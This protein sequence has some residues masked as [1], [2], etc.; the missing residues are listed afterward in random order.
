MLGT[1]PAWLV[2]DAG[3]ACLSQVMVKNGTR[4]GS[5][6][7]KGAAIPAHCL[8]AQR[9][10]RQ[11]GWSL[12]LAAGRWT[13]GKGP[14]EPQAFIC[15]G[16]RLEKQGRVRGLELSH[17]PNQICTP[18]STEPRAQLRKTEPRTKAPSDMQEG[19][20]ASGP[21]P[22]PLPPIFSPGPGEGPLALTPADTTREGL[23]LISFKIRPEIMKSQQMPS[24][25]YRKKS[26][27]SEMAN[28]NM[29]I[30]MITAPIVL[31]VMVRTN[32]NN[33]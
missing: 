8:W 18:P 4:G 2:T 14:R 10:H 5:Q 11:L 19:G 27:D 32:N 9:S 24:E 20:L 25:G 31:I 33:R 7:G 16:V 21:P 1:S 12:P 29:L 26:A 30:V 3:P 6:E 17:T 28:A 15:W 23:G 13:P 22:L